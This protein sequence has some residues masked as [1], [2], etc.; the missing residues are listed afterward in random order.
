MTT[1]K[2]ERAKEL[3]RNATP[4]PWSHCDCGTCG[5]IWN[6]Y[7]EFNLA[8]ADLR[9]DSGAICEDE[10]QANGK[11]IAESRTLLPALAADLEAANQKLAT[12]QAN[13]DT[14]SKHASAERERERLKGELNEA[15]RD[16]DTM[17]ELN[18]TAEAER[19]EIRAELHAVD[20][21][22]VRKIAVLVSDN[23]QLR[24]QL[25]QAERDREAMRAKIEGL[26]RYDA[27]TAY[28]MISKSDGGFLHRGDVLRLFDRPARC[29]FDN[30]TSTAT[31]GPAGEAFACWSHAGDWPEIAKPLEGGA[32]KAEPVCKICNDTHRMEAPERLYPCTHCPVPCEKCR[33]GRSAYC[34]TTPCAC[35]CHRNIKPGN[36]P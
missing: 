33:G 26:T 10:R 32:E 30:C 22:Y 27:H 28:S 18:R 6:A 17:T 31:H 35:G 5:L 9:N 29:R 20:R 13:F 4:G 2:I 16:R 3:D 36:V 1:T 23:K 11:F 34:A 12:L 14:L 7:G 25:S 8:H 15:T 21:D 24:S 19:E